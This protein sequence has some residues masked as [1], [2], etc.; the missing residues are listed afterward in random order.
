VVMSGTGDPDLYVQFGS[1]PTTT[2]Y[3][4]RPYLSGA[5]ETCE[6]TVPAGQTSAYIGVRGYTAGTYTLNI[7]YTSP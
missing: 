6:V 4:C 1:A 7:N 5:A 2:S 3:A